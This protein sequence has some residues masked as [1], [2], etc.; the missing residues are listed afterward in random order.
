M[1]LVDEQRTETELW[2]YTHPQ[3]VTGKTTLGTSMGIRYLVPPLKKPGHEEKGT[4][5]FITGRR[6]VTEGWKPA[7][8]LL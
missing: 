1:P 8:D 2:G 4:S 7:G 6:C 3:N 5:A